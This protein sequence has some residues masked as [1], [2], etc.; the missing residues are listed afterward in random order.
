MNKLEIAI[1]STVHDC[2]I[3]TLT[4]AELMGMSRQILLN[5]AD[6]NKEGS[7]FSPQQITSLQPITGNHSNTDAYVSSKEAAT[8]KGKSIICSLLAVTDKVGQ[9]SGIKK[10]ASWD[11]NPSGFH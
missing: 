11:S 3:G 1:Y 7:Y 5:K 6:P 4:L 2:E 10:P 9:L 8:S